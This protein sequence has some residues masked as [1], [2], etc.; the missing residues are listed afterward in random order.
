MQI[1][2]FSLGYPIILLGEPPFYDQPIF[3]DTSRIIAVRED[4]SQSELQ[5]G[6]YLAIQFIDGSD[7]AFQS[8]QWF[9]C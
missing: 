7:A 1:V 5:Q 6:K 9:A 4:E 2:V 8:T 3:K